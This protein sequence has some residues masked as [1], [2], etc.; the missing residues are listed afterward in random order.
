MLLQSS[1]QITIE[2]RMGFVNT[3]ESQSLPVGVL[4]ILISIL[5]FRNVMIIKYGNQ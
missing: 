5:M 1:L 3:Y 2:L 4:L